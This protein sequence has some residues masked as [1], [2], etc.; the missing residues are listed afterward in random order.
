[1]AAGARKQWSGKDERF[2]QYS[3]RLRTIFHCGRPFSLPRLDA[4]FADG[5]MRAPAKVWRAMAKRSPRRT[6]MD[7]AA[8]LLAKI[9]V[10]LAEHATL[11]AAVSIKSLAAQVS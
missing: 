11:R 1:M 7:D 3:H 6:R 5:V 4:V 2:F 8:T 10:L 9:Q